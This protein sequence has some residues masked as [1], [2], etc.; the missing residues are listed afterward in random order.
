MLDALKAK[1]AEKAKQTADATK[2]Y[3]ENTNIK[4]SDEIREERFNI[5]KSCEEFHKTTEFCRVCGCYMPAK[6]WIASTSCPIKKWVK[7]EKQA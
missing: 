3:L 5:C 7:I 6:T 2:E 1:L 4:V